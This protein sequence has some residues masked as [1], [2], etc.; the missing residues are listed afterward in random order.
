MLP[1]GLDDALKDADVALADG[2]EE[3]ERRADI[4]KSGEHAAPRDGAGKNF[5]GV[6]DFVAHD[7]GEF[8][9][10]QAE[11]N[12]AEGVQDEARVR[13]NVKVGGG[14]V[15]AEAE[16]DDG[17]ESDQNGRCDAGA[18]GAEIV[19]PFTDA[20]TDDIQNHEDCEQCQR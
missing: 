5:L 7:G 17:A 14:D 4:E 19:D 15:G 8:E 1:D 12:Y 9:P 16:I 2:D 10:D 3:R 11:A 13:R 6:F 20:E 18:D